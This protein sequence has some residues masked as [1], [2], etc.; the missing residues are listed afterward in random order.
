MHEGRVV[1]T[2]THAELLA[3]D[4]TYAQLYRLQFAV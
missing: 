4:G 3:Q 1:E 2:G